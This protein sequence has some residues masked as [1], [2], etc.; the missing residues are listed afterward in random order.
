MPISRSGE[1]LLKMGELIHK[2]VELDQRRASSKEYRELHKQMKK[3]GMRVRF[4]KRHPEFPMIVWVISLIVAC[5]I[6]ISFFK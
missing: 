2:K 6:F 4:T 1:E 5:S 3:Y